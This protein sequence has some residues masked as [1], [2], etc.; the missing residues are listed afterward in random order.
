M[1]IKKIKL[2]NMNVDIYL[3]IFLVLFMY[4]MLKIKVL[5]FSFFKKKNISKLYEKY[6]Y[7]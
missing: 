4:N 7:Y 6:N 1:I 2:Y 3:N 5:V